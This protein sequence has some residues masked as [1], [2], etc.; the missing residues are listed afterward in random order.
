[1]TSVR[2][3]DFPVWAVCGPYY[4]EALDPGDVVFFAPKKSATRKAGLDDYVC[5]GILV[6]AEKLPCSK[7]VMADPRLTSEYK[8]KYRSD[9]AAHLRRDREQA[10]R[11]EKIRPCNFVLGDKSKSEWIGRN[12]EYL[13]TALDQAGLHGIAMKLSF[14]RIPALKEQDVRSLYRRLVGKEL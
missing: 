6:V 12:Q 7:D 4:R 1:M 9:L 5:T 10:P 2:L 14:R 13:R 8:K 3:D 11:T